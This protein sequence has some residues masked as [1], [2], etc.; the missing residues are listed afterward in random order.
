MLDN[1]LHVIHWEC[2]ISPVCREPTLLYMGFEPLHH[3]EVSMVYGT[4]SYLSCSPM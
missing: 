2:H 1:Q 4:L 3:G